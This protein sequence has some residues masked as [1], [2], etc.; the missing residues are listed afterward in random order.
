MKPHR[1]RD[2]QLAE[3][4]RQNE[5]AAQLLTQAHGRPVRTAPLRLDLADG[6]CVAQ[7]HINPELRTKHRDAEPVLCAEPSW[8]TIYRHRAYEQPICAA[9]YAWRR[10]KTSHRRNVGASARHNNDGVSVGASA[11]PGNH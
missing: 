2:I 10:Y 5:V 4:H 1:F 9:C 7:A 6:L 3:L 11:H 8:A